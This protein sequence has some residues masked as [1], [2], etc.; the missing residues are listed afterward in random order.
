MPERVIVGFTGVGDEHWHIYLLE[1]VEY[2]VYYK[3]R[4]NHDECLYYYY[5]WMNFGN[6]Q[7]RLG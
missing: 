7:E 4:P 3:R 2:L 1:N 5:V 6:S